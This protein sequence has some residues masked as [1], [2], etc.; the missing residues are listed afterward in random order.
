MQI[1]QEHDE[2]RF[3]TLESEKACRRG[4]TNVDLEGFYQVQKVGWS[5]WACTWSLKIHDMGLEWRINCVVICGC[6][7]EAEGQNGG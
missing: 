3:S 4:A 1:L 5:A 6:F 2:N 7:K